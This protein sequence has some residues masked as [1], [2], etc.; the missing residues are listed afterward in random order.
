[1]CGDLWG[2]LRLQETL[3][4]LQMWQV[5]EHVACKVT[6][7]KAPPIRPHRLHICIAYIA[8]S[9]MRAW[10]THRK[11]ASVRDLNHVFQ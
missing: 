10:L 11:V 9:P 1:M 4:W 2:D 5:F 6:Q 3:P 7:S 8:H